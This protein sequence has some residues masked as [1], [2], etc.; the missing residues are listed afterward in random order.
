MKS[1]Q[2]ALLALALL[3][4]TAG[5]AGDAAKGRVKAAACS[6]CHGPDGLSRMPDTP[7]IAGQP[8]IYLS[9]QLKAYRSGKRVHDTMS[10]M[11]KS[12]KDEDIDDLAAWFSSIAIKAEVPK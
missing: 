5:R 11:A 6:A 1:S 9:A 7:H 12:L 8:E 4:P 3:A 2:V 10:L